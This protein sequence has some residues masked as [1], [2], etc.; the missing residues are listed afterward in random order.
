MEE[1]NTGCLDCDSGILPLSYRAS[2]KCFSDIC[3]IFRCTALFRASA[4]R[5]LVTIDGLVTYHFS[6]LLEF[7]LAWE[8]SDESTNDN[9]QL[10]LCL[11]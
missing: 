4:Q 5:V 9:D 10:P 3:N 1:S 11:C 8:Q 6:A 2:R 7:C